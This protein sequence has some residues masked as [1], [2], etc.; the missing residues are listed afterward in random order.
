MP[1][2]FYLPQTAHEPEAVPN[3]PAGGLSGSIPTWG[4]TRENITRE[5]Y[6][7]QNI[8]EILKEIGVEVPE[9]K[10]EALNKKVSENYK[11]AAEFDKK[12]GKIEQE[13]DN[14][15]SQL[16]TANET[17]KGFEGVDL[18]TINQQLK[19]YQ[20]KA[21]KAERDAKEQLAARDFEDALKTA[22]E[23]LKFTSDAAKRAVMDE[24][25]G[26]GLKL[27]GGK[28]LGFDDAIGVIKARDASAF[29]DEQQA[30]ADAKRARFTDRMNTPGNPGGGDGPSFAAQRLKQFREE[31]YG[32]IKED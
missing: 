1:T 30:E 20:E 7:M 26:K 27:D 24:V 3:Y 18:N 31:R 32:K 5:G 22:F 6:V 25:R 28:I 23:S 12:I 21:E 16:N 13:R 2:L 10:T 19:D 4:R 17:L 14:Y 15:K 9:D 11:T 8:I 29:V